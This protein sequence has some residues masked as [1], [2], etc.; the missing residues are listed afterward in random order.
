[1]SKD[2][3][4]GPLKGY[5]C[6]GVERVTRDQSRTRVALAARIREYWPFN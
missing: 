2:L 3:P 4:P 6:L 1:M 5:A